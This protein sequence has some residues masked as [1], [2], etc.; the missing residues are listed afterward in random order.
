[1]KIDDLTNDRKEEYVGIRS[2]INHKTG[3]KKDGQECQ[4][5]WSEGLKRLDIVLNI[6]PSLYTFPS[7]EGWKDLSANF[8]GVCGWRVSVVLFPMRFVSA[9][10]VYFWKSCCEFLLWGLEA[11]QHVGYSR[12]VHWA[13]EVRV[14]PSVLTMARIN[15]NGLGHMNMIMKCFLVSIGRLHL[16]HYDQYDHDVTS[17]GWKHETRAW[18]KEENPALISSVSI[19]YKRNE[20]SLE[21]SREW[22]ISLSGVALRILS[23]LVSCRL[24]LLW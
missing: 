12:W 20:C 1:M 6:A 11:P 14:V 8:V 17:G 4:C 5:V 24:P 9:Q 19:K 10:Q 3:R 7:N 21:S 13:F 2:R 18:M 15:G 23:Y 16:A 22:F